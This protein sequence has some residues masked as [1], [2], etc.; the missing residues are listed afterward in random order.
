ML[1]ELNILEPIMILNSRRDTPGVTPGQSADILSVLFV[2]TTAP[3]FY[4]L[5]LSTSLP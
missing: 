2:L 5:M 4:I 1:S 3:A